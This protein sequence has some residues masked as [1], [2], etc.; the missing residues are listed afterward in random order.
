MAA[1]AVATAGLNNSISTPTDYS[2]ESRGDC[3]RIGFVVGT[4]SGSLFTDLLFLFDHSFLSHAKW[5]PWHNYQMPIVCI[6]KRVA[7]SHS[8]ECTCKRNKIVCLV[9]CGQFWCGLWCFDCIMKSCSIH[10]DKKKKKNGHPH[11]KWLH[12][13]AND[14]ASDAYHILVYNV[15]LPL[16]L[17]LLYFYCMSGLFDSSSSQT[18][19]KTKASQETNTAHLQ[20]LLGVAP[21]GPVPLNKERCYQLAMLETAYHHLPLP[22]DSEKVRYSISFTELVCQCKRLNWKPQSLFQLKLTV[23]LL[24]ICMQACIQIQYFTYG[25]SFDMWGV[26][27]FCTW[28]QL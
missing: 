25:I 27:Q 9:I 26:D 23:R 3:G 16:F 10:E 24:P 20:P 11:W 28:F 5:K 14:F 19:D 2:T 17:L 1:Q 4:C 18:T 21:L 22:A 7:V 6:V 13:Q 8:G 15:I 12:W